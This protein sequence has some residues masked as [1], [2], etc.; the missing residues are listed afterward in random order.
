MEIDFDPEKDA[1][2]LTKH[3]LSLGDFD[4]FDDDPI[5]LV[6]DRFDY[7]ETR[8]RAFGTIDGKPYVVVYTLIGDGIRV[9]SF[10]RS[11]AKEGRQYVRRRKT[12]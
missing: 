9:I 7:G 12:A 3:G 5:I 6:D 11:S 4:G 2:N 10:R 1:A 8:Y